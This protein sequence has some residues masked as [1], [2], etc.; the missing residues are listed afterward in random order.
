VTKGKQLHQFS[1]AMHFVHTASS[2]EAHR[3]SRELNGKIE[4]DGYHVKMDPA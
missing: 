1:G 3:V 2:K 4:K